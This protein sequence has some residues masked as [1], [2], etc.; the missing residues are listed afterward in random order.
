MQQPEVELALEWA[1]A[2]GW[3]P[4]LRDAH[5]FFAADPDGF[6]VAEHNGRA[7]GC[8]SAV[9]YDPVFGFLGLYMV[10]PEFRGQGIGMRLWETAM[11]YLGSRNVGLDG[12]IAQQPNYLKSGFHFAHRNVRFGGVAQGS[13]HPDCVD[14]AEVSFAA[15]F[16][17]DSELFPAPREAFLRH[18]IHPDNGT[19][20]A[21]CRGDSLRGY[22]VLRP[23]RTGYKIGPL[24]ADDEAAAE[25]IFETLASGVAGAPVYL[26]VVE[27]NGDALALAGRHGLIKVFETARMYTRTAPA[28]PMHRIYGITTIE[29]G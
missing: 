24:F 13:R 27:T 4:G 2:E 10:L 22:G 9:A 25:A 5:A 6:F 12:V 17:Y 7:V 23:C 28:L 1:A 14:L 3:N 8:V 11:S 18:W 26:D 21:V 20:V 19:A 15:V 16:A 29:L